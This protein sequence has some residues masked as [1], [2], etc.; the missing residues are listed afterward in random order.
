MSILADHRTRFVLQGITGRFGRHY[1]PLMRA[2]GT[3]IVAGVTPGRGGESVEGVPVFDTV[4]E[5]VAVRQAEA[6]IVLVPGLAARDAIL[7]A[8]EAGLRL[9]VALMDGVPI[10][11][12]L[13][14]KR[15][16]RERDVVLIGPNSP[17]LITPGQCLA[18]FIPPHSCMPGPV[19]IV[20]R[21][22]TLTYQTAHLLK[23]TGIGQS[24]AVGIGG[25]P[26]VGSTLV[27]VLTSFETDPDTKAVVLLGEVGGTMEEDVAAFVREGGFSKPLVAFIAGRLAPPD[28][29]MGHAGA[30]VM[31]R[32]ETY[33]AKVEALRQ[34]GVA[35]ADLLTQIPTMIAQRL[36]T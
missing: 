31:G 3:Q 30:I 16:L 4:A 22:G 35:V 5:A 17:G 26:V 24:T 19:G 20:S 12:M 34:A 14:V 9:I 7:E 32:G 8:A 33:E 15:R 29:P 10:Q 28:R 2:Y 13:W 23:Q 25:D 11:D 1:G 27:D 36:M 21:S 6:S 18:G